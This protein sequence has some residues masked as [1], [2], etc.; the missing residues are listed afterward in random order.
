MQ[1]HALSSVFAN[2]D[3]KISAPDAYTGQLQ[4]AKSPN[5]MAALFGQQIL[6]LGYYH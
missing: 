5:V 2:I 3:V 4:G 6:D 1:R